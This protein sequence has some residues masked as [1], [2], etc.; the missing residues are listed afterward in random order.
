MDHD[1]HDAPR[2]TCQVKTVECQESRI[3]IKN[4]EEEQLS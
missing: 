2:V 1:Y 3:V 4:Q